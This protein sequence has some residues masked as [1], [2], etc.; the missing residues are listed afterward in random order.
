MNVLDLVLVG[1]VVAGVVWG[2]RTGFVVQFGTYLG[3]I[4]GGLLGALLAGAIADWTTSPFASMVVSLTVVMVGAALAGGLGGAGGVRLLRAVH[5][6]R[7]AAVDGALGGLTAGVGVLAMVWLMTGSLAT[8]P[9]A[10]I[11][12]AIQSSTIV[13][14]LDSSLPPVPEVAARLSRLTDPLGFP[15]VFAG[16]EPSP[17]PPVAGPVTADVQ[18]AV[19]SAA[20]STVQILGEGCGGVLVGSGWIAGDALVATNAHVIAGIDRPIVRDADGDHRAVP[21]VFDPDGDIAVL[22]VSGLSGPPLALVEPDVARGAV[23]AVLGYPNGGSLAASA[24]AVRDTYDALGRDIYGMRL[25]TRSI[26]ELQATIQPGNSGGPFVLPDGRVAG[27]VFARSVPRR[28]HGLR[29]AGIGA[30]R[31]SCRGGRVRRGVHRWVCRLETRCLSHTPWGIKPTGPARC[32]V[33]SAGGGDRMDAM[34]DC[35]GPAGSRPIWFRPAEPYR[36]GG[37]AMTDGNLAWRKCPGCGYLVPGDAARCLRCHTDLAA[38]A[39]AVPAA[40]ETGAAPASPA[41][42]GPAPASEFGPI[43]P[44]AASAAAPPP[45]PGPPT[46]YAPVPPTAGEYLP[47]PSGGRSSRRRRVIAALAIVLV[48]GLAGVLVFA[49]GSDYPSRWDSRLGD[50]P[51]TVE[52]LR[53]LRFDHAVPVRFLSDA[54]FRKETAIVPGT[55]K[56]EVRQMKRLA[57]GLRAAGL[58]TGEVDLAQ[59]VNDDQQASV[60]AFYDPD[61]KEVV[62]RGTGRLDVEHRVTLAHELTHVLQDQ[63]FDLNKLEAK[64]DESADGSGDAFRAFVEGD[65]GRIEDRYLNRLSRADQR[66]YEDSIF[67]EGERISEE[68]ADVPEFVSLLL[69]APYR[70]GPASVQVVAAD[71]GNKNVDRGFRTGSFTERLFLE[72]NSVLHHHAEPKVRA[73]AVRKGEKG[74]GKSEGFGAFS[75]YLLLGSRLEPGASLETAMQVSGG[76][77]RQVRMGERNCVRGVIAGRDRAANRSLQGDLGRWAAALPAGM[78]EI[79]RRGPAVTFF[80]C[81]PGAT[82]DLTSPDAALA[83]AATLLQIHDELEAALVSDFADAGMPARVAQ[84]AAL[85]VVTSPQMAVVIRTPEADLKPKQVTKAIMDSADAVREECGF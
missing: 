67:A 2:A 52:Q 47:A 28:R 25:V 45:P 22:R 49:T 71:G 53:G 85:G 69:S 20:P 12:E 65:A 32:R 61:V 26:A 77:M 30:A 78:A 19:D 27:M 50:L 23:G 21:V 31:R 3:L 17:A 15:R 66:E 36:A 55:S 33:A 59:A 40:P 24:A 34:L 5:R 13:R 16:L 74:V 54:K 79:G 63:H 4:G 68:T 29:A 76:Q 82:A 60:L 56:R 38:V 75:T 14:W 37:N 10:G 83:R 80:S 41:P 70:Y 46:P 8:L 9:R 81:D 57:A 73:P 44:P 51:K 39:A 62:V 58:V 43:P 6:A 11:G 64:T 7:L 48:A 35:S 42:A 72:P 1:L 18:A 84:C